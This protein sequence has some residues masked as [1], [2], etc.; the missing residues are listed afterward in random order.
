MAAPGAID[1]TDTT[2]EAEV[3]V[4]SDEVPVVVDLW[5][6]WCGP[7]KTLGPI[8]EKVVGETD[9]AVALA[10][11]NVDENPRASS[12]FKVQS[13]P[14]VYALRGRQIVDH[15]IGALPEGAVRQ[16]VDRLAPTPSAADLLVQAGDE[17]SLR[18]ALELEPDHVAAVAALGELLA[19]RGE[20]EEAL[21]LL[22]RIPETAETR[23]IAAL[24]RMAATSVGAPAADEDVEVRLEGLLG[25]VRDDE[26]ARQEFID[27]LE[28][29]GP[30]DPRSV[31]YRRKLT[32]RL[33]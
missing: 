29:L 18:E 24:A 19:G 22:A 21:A 25:R 9:G 1:V 6:P 33:F 11:I 14:A 16:F 3:L 30:D 7:C 5:A 26:A 32:S 28:V 12:T 10:K 4:R 23:R 27:L 15:F 31:A 17:A 8:L 20:A 2:F 13:I